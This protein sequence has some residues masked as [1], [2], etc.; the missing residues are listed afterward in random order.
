MLD[1]LSSG[2]LSV[3]LDMTGLKLSRE[4]AVELVLGPA[5]PGY[6]LAEIADPP[7][8][9]Q[10]QQYLQGLVAKGLQREGQGVWVQSSHQ[11]LANHQGTVPLP[12]ASIT[13][14]ATSLA[15]LLTWD[16]DHQFEI[17]IGTT[18]KI[19][20]GVLQGDL[21]V[22][23][24]DDPFFIWEEA[25]VLGNTLNQMGIRQV[26]GNLIITGNFSMN[27]YENPEVSAEMLREALNESLW[28][29]E[30]AQA[31]WQMA[32]GTPKPQVAI[33][34]QIAIAD[35]PIPN[36]T[37]LVRHRSLPLRDLLQQMNIYSNNV[38]AQMLADALGGVNKVRKLSS[39]AAG[40]P[41]SEI[42]LI[43]G[44]GLGQENQISPRAACGMFM[45]IQQLL[46]PQNLTLSD[47]FPVSGRD[48]GTMD[49]RAI[50]GGAVVKTGT[51]WDV[52]ALAGILP[53]QD[54]GWICFAILNR[55]NYL[56]GFRQE[57]DKL[58]TR[59]LQTWQTKLLP[60]SAVHNLFDGYS[61]QGHLDA[62]KRNE[63]LF[64]YGG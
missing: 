22:T 51:L 35:K 33:A 53:T 48:G 44:S 26:T 27:F 46:Q 42:K 19:V 61:S 2:L 8:D 34:G 52:S 31:Y 5:I 17:L 13:K 63:I 23:G 45:A 20:D 9:Q 59:F 12:A 21:I 14:V 1:L 3:W 60:P 16:I 15:A 41:L 18:G 56:D 64:E 62:V 54:K 4:N 36:Q 11:L 43:N 7:T 24:G 50:P 55:G 32:P 38:M 49:Y 57:Q 10:V 40:V 30:A 39:E 47:L 25:I 29:E 6:V 28:T 37:L 58:L